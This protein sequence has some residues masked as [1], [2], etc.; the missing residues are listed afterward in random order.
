MSRAFSSK[1]AYSFVLLLLLGGGASAQQPVAGH[2]RI[3]LDKSDIHWL[4]YKAGALSRLGHNHVI[5]VG[6][7]SGD[8]N[9]AP[10]LADSRF[11]MEIPV[12]GLVVDN[13]ALRAKEGDDFASQPT[14]KDIEGTRHNM[15]SDKLLN[16]D[17]YPALK[18]TGSGPT[19]TAGRQQLHLTIDIVGHSV[20]LDVPVELRADGDT[21]EA[22]G[23]FQLTHE[24]LG[25]KPFS[26]MMGALQVADQMN[27]A[28]RVTAHRIE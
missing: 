1:F 25:L 12:A 13:P 26:I 9:V 15:L 21:L 10:N 27:F 2:Y 18:I 22:S 3:D 8:V 5:S 28:Y 11:E 20:E 7:I 16:G 19:G 6:K 23:T 4:V 24:A 14:P 17:Q